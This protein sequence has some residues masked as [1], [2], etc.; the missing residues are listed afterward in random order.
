MATVT[1]LKNNTF[2][3]RD[4]HGFPVL[5]DADA[6]GAPCPTEL[7]VMALGCC[8]STDLVNGIVAAGAA[9]HGCELTTH[10]TLRDAS[11]RI[12]TAIELEFDIRADGV[13][14]ATVERI[15]AD[16]LDKY[17]HVCLMLGGSI[18]LST[19]FTLRG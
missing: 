6:N 3:A 12:Y 19:S 9:L 11:P 13:D 16:A 8:C 14:E 7:L 17:C 10:E 2:L 15:L 4:S 5:V 1:H 18:K